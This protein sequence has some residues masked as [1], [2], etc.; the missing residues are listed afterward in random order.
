MNSSWLRMSMSRATQLDG[1][2]A[3]DK[4]N[5]TAGTIDG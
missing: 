5:R 2:Q 1:N 3:G 4:A